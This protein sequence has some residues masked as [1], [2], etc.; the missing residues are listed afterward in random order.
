M[1]LIG[2]TKRIHLL[3]YLPAGN[4]SASMVPLIQVSGNQARC[5]LICLPP[6]V[7]R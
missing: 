6:S 1:V 2:I 7:A 5:V 4:P 3:L